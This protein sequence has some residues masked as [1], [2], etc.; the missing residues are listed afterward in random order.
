MRGGLL[1]L[2]AT[3]AFTLVAGAADAQTAGSSPGRPG[4]P[5]GGVLVEPASYAKPPKNRTRSARAVIAAARAH[6]KIR[7]EIRKYPTAYVRAYLKG[8]TGWQV[9]WLVPPR[10]R[11][12]HTTEI[13]QV[14]VDD[15][16]GEVTEAWTGVQVA[17]TMARGYPGAFG[18]AV[19]APYIWIPLCLLFLLPF[20]PLRHPFSRLRMVHMDLVV[21]LSF[22]V[23]YAFFNA[24]E[25]GA[26]VPLSYLPLAYLAVRMVRVAQRR[27]AEGLATWMSLDMLGIAIVFL[28]GF[29]LGLNFTNSNVIDVGY[30]GVIGAD[31]IAHGEPL[32]GNFPRDDV[33]G[34]TYGPVAYLAYLP[35]ELL[36][37]WHGKWDGLPAAHGAAV[38]FDLST[39]ALLYVLGR[40]HGGA[41]TGALLSYLWAACPFSLLV[42]NSN[43]NDALVGALLL[44]ALLVAG[45]PVA[46]GGVLAL[47]GLTKFAP[48]ALVPLFARPGR[49]RVAAG[50][51]GTA[52]LVTVPVLA[53]GGLDAFYDRTLGF[54]GDRSSPF[55]IWGYYGT[56]DG[57]QALAQFAA[58]AFAVVLGFVRVPRDTA[59]LAALAAAVLIAFQLAVTHWFYLYLGWFV[60][61]VLV[62]LVI[63]R[64]DAG[65]TRS[66]PPFAVPR[67]G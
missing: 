53:P 48:L 32:Y 22:S 56:L 45:R 60:P 21:I 57:L 39:L 15:R 28:V 26:S 9:S 46:R 62:A 51:A 64:G 7:E 2:V 29:R 36:F 11:G 43:S 20:I 27:P 23:S 1:A 34:D 33:H 67:S 42:A 14:L 58:V 35:F 31:R 52:V 18:R 6:P 50:F 10:G 13:A 66:T 38:L 8:P 55:S 25:L 47:A 54:Q 63:P 17:W 59:G 30:S 61:L 3:L 24:A 19:N 41:H 65:R 37:G 16:T 49:A 4:A 40:R 12:G 44:L 5:I